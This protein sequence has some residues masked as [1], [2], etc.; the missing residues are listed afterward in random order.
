MADLIELGRRTRRFVR[1]PTDSRFAKA[2]SGLGSGEGRRSS[3]SPGFSFTADPETTCGL[4]FF[5]RR[6][7]IASLIRILTS[8]VRK[9]LWF[10]N[11]GRLR[12]AR[13]MQFWT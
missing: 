3:H 9:A 4:A 1:A 5:L 12:K 10:S 7:A 11:F 6:I 13:T 2:C 8:Q